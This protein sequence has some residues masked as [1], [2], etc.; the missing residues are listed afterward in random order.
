MRHGVLVPEQL[1]RAARSPFTADPPSEFGRLF[2]AE[3]E[4]P[5]DII[6]AL[7]GRSGGQMLDTALPPGQPDPNDSNIPAGFTFFGQ[8]VDHDITFMQSPPTL[9]LPQDTSTVRNLRT[10]R[11]DLDSVFGA[12]PFD[13]ASASLYNQDTMELLLSPS[14][15]DIPR[16][17]NGNPRK[18]IAEPRN[19][20]NLIVV[21][22]HVLF[23][24]LYNVFVNEERAK[25]RNPNRN[26]DQEK[27]RWYLDAR[28]RT[29]LHYQN[30]VLK[31]YLP[32]IIGQQAIDDAIAREARVYFQM[33]RR[34]RRSG[35]DSRFIM[36]LE[37]AFAAFRFGHTQV[38]NGYLLNPTTG[39][40]LFGGQ[41]PIDLNGDQP[42]TD[43]L[44]IDWD[45]F[46]E[47]AETNGGG[48]NPRRNR[49][50]RL[51]TRLADSLGQLRPPGIGDVPV[52]LAERNLRRGRAF[53]LPSGQA[54]ASAIGVA[55]IPAGQLGIGPDLTRAE[56]EERENLGGTA[57]SLIDRTPL[58]YY[59]LREA[60]LNGGSQLTGVGAFL[61]AETFV[62][63]LLADRQSI[64]HEPDFAANGRFASMALI[65]RNA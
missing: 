64:L 4:Q 44:T 33:V 48:A 60:E 17:N 25:D 47:V 19:D 32:R 55:P 39:A 26:N 8:F 65:A 5:S 9:G 12:G 50:R 28:R 42:V 13:P 58:W 23:I 21:Q 2:P 7:L 11:F 36:P 29:V 49:A 38:R 10:P 43:N 24:R 51:D 16:T 30:V 53:Q 15:R 52:S 40:Q 18:L 22:L 6:L 37:F 20:E 59:I 41:G 61:L 57:P 62:G 34:S 54:I 63:L 3:V 45:L 27:R 46:F 1:G 31:D 56:Q 14:G 35:E